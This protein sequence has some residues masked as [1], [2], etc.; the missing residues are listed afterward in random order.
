MTDLR[1]VVIV[2]LMG[3][4]K[5]TVGRALAAAVGYRFVDSDAVIEAEY[6]STS[7]ELAAQRG[8]E[9]LHGIEA[10]QLI[11]ALESPTTEPVVIAAAAS[12]AEDAAAV[13][14]LRDV[15]TVWLTASSD[16]LAGRLPAE[17]HR[18]PLGADP[19]G[20]L[21]DQKAAR[22]DAFETVA[23]VRVHVEGRT[24][25]E[26]V[27]EI[28]ARVNELPPPVSHRQADV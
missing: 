24:V 27:D 28:R 20:A 21:A 12:V 8:V 14:A 6:G 23:N 15:I 3:V 19:V 18:R 9:A 2:G 26:L 7:A 1:P 22:R 17:P 16:F 13:A 5:T 11:R 10:Q 25:A 4:G